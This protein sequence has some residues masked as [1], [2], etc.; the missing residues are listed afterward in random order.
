[1]KEF[2]KKIF[3]SIYRFLTKIP[4][5]AFSRF[6]ISIGYFIKSEAQY[7]NNKARIVNWDRLDLHKLLSTEYVKPDEAIIFLEF[8]VFRGQT[9]LIW[10][11]NNQNPDSVFT[12]F[13]TFSGLP[14]DWGSVKKGSFS[15]QG[16]LPE[17]DDPRASFCVGLIQDTLPAFIKNLTKGKRKVIHIDVDLYNATLITLIYLQPFLEKGDIIIFDDFYTMTKASHEFRAFLDYQLLYKIS[18]KPLINVRNGH[19]VLEIL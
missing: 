18:Y 2:S 11:K 10:L 19:F 17:V 7:N 14:E 8:G 4:T 1:M 6:F 3:Y 15:A 16:K 12:G 5:S 13:D 9:F